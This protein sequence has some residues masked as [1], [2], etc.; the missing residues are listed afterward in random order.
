MGKGFITLLFPATSKWP[1]WLSLAFISRLIFFL[2][3]IHFSQY[4]HFPGFWGGLRGDSEGYMLPFE[5]LIK[6][7]SYTP[8]YRMP[9]FGV[10]YYPLLLV[11]SKATAC[12]ILIIIQLLL[13]SLS[14]YVLALTVKKIFKSNTLFYLTF[15][16]YTTSIFSSIQDPV[17]ISESLTTS[18]LILSIHFFARYF[19]KY[20][21]KELI[22]SGSFLTWTTFLRPIF[23]PLFLILFVLAV[24]V[25]M[26]SKRKMF[27]AFLLLLPI[28][29]I[30]GAW[31]VRNYINYKKIAPLTKT[32]YFPWIENTHL[33]S[34]IEF[35]QSW[36]GAIWFVDPKAEISWFGNGKP[37]T[38][39]SGS[40]NDSVPFPGYIYTSQFNADSLKTL[41]NLITRMTTDSC[42][43]TL[44]KS[45]YQRT[46][47]E[48]FNRYTLSE[49]KE[50]PYVFYIKSNEKRLNALLFSIHPVT[51]LYINNTISK[52]YN[53]YYYI[54]LSFGFLGIL[55]MLPLI[56]KLYLNCI[57]PA[58]PV[59]TILI[60]A[61]VIRENENRYLIPA[62][63]FIVICAGYCLYW[64]LNKFSPSLVNKLEATDL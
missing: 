18:T 31:I 40:K 52:F 45:D 48:K 49:K 10:L 6:T 44:Q 19:D 60:H 33:K 34:M 56:F 46:V 1:Y 54:I 36:G 22:F 27:P 21:I 29:I 20:E 63:P 12:N 15:L 51:K 58:I 37:C 47:I 14:V 23:S 57:I 5:N 2:L 26:R 17:L 9:G 28:A 24:I 55:L 53:A 13:S 43:S 59:F 62:Y 25:L 3:V 4:N 38:F 50:N 64:L 30:D 42:L 61:V 11:F 41:K 8:D 7:G 35:T 39:G 16:I 32:V